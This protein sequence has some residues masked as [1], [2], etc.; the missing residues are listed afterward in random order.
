MIIAVQLVDYCRA[1]GNFLYDLCNSKL[2]SHY[3]IRLLFV[4]IRENNKKPLVRSVFDPVK[5]CWTLECYVHFKK[6]DNFS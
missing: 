1:I 5:S 2:R 6:L 4:E 3:K